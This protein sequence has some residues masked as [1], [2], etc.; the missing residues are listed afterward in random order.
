MIGCRPFTPSELSDISAAF[1]GPFE[2]RD[3]LLFWLGTTTGFR[4]SELLSL[5]V[6]DLWRSG[7][8]S[9]RVNIRR[10]NTKGKRHGQSAHLAPVV[11][12]L[13]RRW[14]FDYWRRWP[15]DPKAPLFRSRSGVARSISRMQGHRI[16]AAAYV[17]ACIEGGPGE[18]ATHCMRKTYAQRMHEHFGDIF[19]VQKALRHASPTSTVAYLS[20]EDS[21]LVQA[22]DI[23]WPDEREKSPK[24]RP[25]ASK[26]LQFE[27]SQDHV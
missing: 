10:R 15:T 9:E 23:Q 16:L 21:D 19:M 17:R 11:S 20:F 26:I 12:P 7:R 27:R 14:L 1:H 24:E 8:P 3:R 5:V 2:H 18:L 6:A 13:I 25:I 4:I 22:I